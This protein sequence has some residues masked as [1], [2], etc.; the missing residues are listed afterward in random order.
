M[1]NKDLETLINKDG[2][3]VFEFK[4]MFNRLADQFSVIPTQQGFEDNNPTKLNLKSPIIREW[5]KYCHVRY[6]EPLNVQY[7][8]G[9]T[10]GPASGILVLDVDDLDK[11]K[12]YCTANSIDYKFSTFIVKT[13][14]EG[15]GYHLYFKYPD[16]GKQYGNKSYKD[17]G[18]DIRGVG[19]FVIAPGSL[20]PKSKK[21]YTVINSVEAM[22]IP[23]WILGLYNVDEGLTAKPTVDLSNIAPTILELIEKGMPKGERSEASM[24][25]MVYLTSNGFTDNQIHEIFSFYPV[26]E[27]AREHKKDWFDKELQKAKSY[28]AQQ[29]NQEK[30]SR[31]RYTVRSLQDIRNKD[32]QFEYIVDG[33]LPKD[34]TLLIIGKSGTCKSTLAMQYAVDILNP[35]QKLFLGK[36]AIVDKNRYKRVLF[37]QAENT[38]FGLKKRSIDMIKGIQS[39]NIDTIFANIFFLENDNL[40]RMVGEN[41]LNTAF[42]ETIETTIS[43]N[44][45]DLTILDPLQCFHVQNE[46]DNGQMRLIL[47]K[48]ERSVRKHGSGLVVVHHDGKSADVKNSTGGR[49]A[50][51]ISDWA[52]NSVRI[53]KKDG[54][55]IVE[56]IKSRNS[57]PFNPVHL[58]LNNSRLESI[59]KGNYLAAKSDVVYLIDALQSMGGKASSKQVLVKSAATILQAN[60]RNH[61]NFSVNK[62]ID[63]A[64]NS[65]KIQMTKGSGNSIEYTL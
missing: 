58:M 57:M 11:F 16:D 7:R 35:N 3:D 2:K 15:G 28:A 1:I 54:T 62:L 47:D 19:G 36:F 30:T 41:I 42:L 45:I 33:F 4:T 50:S 10:C 48:L 21:S 5:Q 32:I 34:E 38:E 53:L 37:I 59:N 44:N 56:S 52:A 24:K 51:S 25:V 43:N 46:M 64:V 22:D 60:N 9:I 27:K 17:Y 6:D 29:Q 26:G 13:G 61:S 65:N 20:H 14:R 31:G 49:G 39:E 23:A 55:F 18:F 12:G 8:A 40:A 63:D